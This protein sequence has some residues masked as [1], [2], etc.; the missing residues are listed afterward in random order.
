M[1]RKRIL[2]PPVTE[3]TQPFWDA[4][5]DRRLVLQWCA[6]CDHVVWFPRG[7]SRLLRRHARMEAGDRAR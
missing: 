2:E 4:T 3:T 5:R 6:Q 1:E 7:V